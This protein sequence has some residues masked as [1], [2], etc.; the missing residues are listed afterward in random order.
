MVKAVK[1]PEG[2]RALMSAFPHAGRVVWI[3]LRPAPRVPMQIV[4]QVDAVAGRGLKGDRTAEKARPGND[5]QVTLIQA[6]HLEAVGALLRRAAIEPALARRNVVVSGINLASLKGH[7][8]HIG[9]A[10]LEW[11]GECHPCSMMEAAL[12]EGGYNAMRGH[13]GITARV[14]EGGMMRIGAAVNA[15]DFFQSIDTP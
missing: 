10:V 15:I 6:E 4:T 7:A 2:L 9:D 1:I 11:T 13:G 8:F 12:G 3:G 5:R 14:R